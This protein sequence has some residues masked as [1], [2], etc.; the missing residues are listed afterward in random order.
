MHISHA[1]LC[2][3]VVNTIVVA[4]LYAQ[5]VPDTHKMWRRDISESVNPIADGH[6]DRVTANG[7]A[8]PFLF[9]VRGSFQACE[10]GWVYQTVPDRGRRLLLSLGPTGVH[11]DKGGL[12]AEGV[13][14]AYPKLVAAVSPTKCVL[15]LVGP[16]TFPN[17]PPDRGITATT[18]VVEYD[19]V[20]RKF[21][22]ITVSPVGAERHVEALRWFPQRQVLL[23]AES[24]DIAGGNTPL[25][26]PETTQPY[27]IV[28]PA[29]RKRPIAE[30][31]EIVA[32]YRRHQSFRIRHAVVGDGDTARSQWTISQLGR[33]TPLSYETSATGTGLLGFPISDRILCLSHFSRGTWF[34]DSAQSVEFLMGS[35]VAIDYDD[36]TQRLAMRS[37]DMDGDGNY[38]YWSVD[39]ARYFREVKELLEL[40]Q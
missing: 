22:V 20:T 17:A 36:A 10:F 26:D 38:N 29:R 25:P 21:D 15:N 1:V 18:L 6:L 5:R 40:D 14:V 2:I 28:M 19:T 16:S 27:C 11:D 12:V 13:Q 4:P 8:G 35:H 9:H 7:D 24:R 23:L 3:V 32:W 37:R 31:P 33:R 34:V 39:V 30:F